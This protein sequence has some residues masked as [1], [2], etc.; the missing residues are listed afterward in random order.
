MKKYSKQQNVCIIGTGFGGLAAGVLLIKKGYMV[1]IFERTEI[2]GG[3]ASSYIPSS[4]GLSYYRNLLSKFKI[5][6][7][8]SVPDL[9]TIFEKEMIDGYKLDSGF[10]LIGG[11][12]KYVADGDFADI[13]SGLGF[14]G[15]RTGFV[16]DEGYRYHFF[17]NL[18]KI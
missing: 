18:E 9:E 10:H 11:G 4:L 7:P 14:L 16:T 1:T 6:V 2:L 17:S 15:S 8:F 13:G 12:R 5:S 3:R